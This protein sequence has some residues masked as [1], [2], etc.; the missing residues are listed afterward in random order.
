MTGWGCLSIWKHCLSFVWSLLTKPPVVVR[1]THAFRNMYGIRNSV[2]PHRCGKE[3]E[4]LNEYPPRYASCRLEFQICACF[5]LP[6]G[7]TN[8]KPSVGTQ[9]RY[10]FLQVCVL[11]PTPI[12]TTASLDENLGALLENR[13]RK[14]TS[15]SVLFIRKR[16]VMS[17][18]SVALAKSHMKTLSPA[19]T[20]PGSSL[21]KLLIKE[22]ER[23][24]M[25]IATTPLIFKNGF[26]T[27]ILAA[28]FITR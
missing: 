24:C 25:M 2:R 13:E 27:I 11:R 18:S 10:L 7:V 23:V 22:L 15:Y 16:R 1:Q 28:Q 4:A 20:T 6:G 14:T 19:S 8:P 3:N 5:F 12:T 17:Q 9:L 26:S 21:M